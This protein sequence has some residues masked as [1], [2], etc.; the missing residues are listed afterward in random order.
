MGI[1]KFIESVCV[2]PAVYWGN[3]EPDG[4]GGMT[5]SD[6]VE[7]KVRWDDTTE[8]VT[9]KDGKERVSKAELLVTDDLS[10]EGIVWL[11]SKE[12]LLEETGE[13]QFEN[14]LPTMISNTYEIIRFDRIPLFRSK[15]EF[16]KKAYL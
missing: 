7:I 5:Y 14:I 16:V 6:P 9:D 4:Y 8:I 1:L 15:D 3:P 10:T 11:G 13:S 2:Q 12:Q